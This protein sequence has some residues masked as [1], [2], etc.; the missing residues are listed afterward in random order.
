MKSEFGKIEFGRIC[1]GS[2]C[3]DEDVIVKKQKLEKRG[4]RKDNHVLSVEELKN[5]L[6]PRTKKVV[7]GT[8]IHGVLKVPAETKRF[9]E[10]K[11]IALVQDLSPKAAEAYNQEKH[12]E[13]VLAIIHSTC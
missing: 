3:F 5:Y 8:G 13:N 7:V 12:K 6:T 2:Q 1:F 4:P 10:S 9:L 11:N